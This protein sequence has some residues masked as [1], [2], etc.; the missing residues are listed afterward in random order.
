MYKEETFLHA[1]NKFDGL[2]DLTVYGKP[3]TSAHLPAYNPAP[4][5]PPTNAEAE[6]APVAASDA[7]DGD[8]FADVNDVSHGSGDLQ[9]DTALPD[10]DVDAE[11]D[12]LT[13]A[14]IPQPPTQAISSTPGASGSGLHQFA[15]NNLAMLDDA[16]ASLESN[17]LAAQGT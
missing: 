4:T 5:A 6:V 16:I 2:K 7:Y 13:H 8:G 12:D 11:Q 1:L 10:V 17:P 3:L 14:D 15:P 9:D